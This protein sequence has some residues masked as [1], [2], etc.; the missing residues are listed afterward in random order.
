MEWNTK[1]LIINQISNPAGHD[2]EVVAKKD[3]NIDI[4]RV[5]PS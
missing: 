3:G 2:I 5:A 4:N 1:Q